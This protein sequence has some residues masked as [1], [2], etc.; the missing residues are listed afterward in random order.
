[1]NFS[2]FEALCTEQQVELHSAIV[3][4]G[5]AKSSGTLFVLE[6]NSVYAA[7]NVAGKLLRKDPDLRLANTTVAI[8]EELAQKPQSFAAGVLSKIIAASIEPVPAPDFDRTFICRNAKSIDSCSNAEGSFSLTFTQ[9]QTPRVALEGYYRPI[10]YQII[11]GQNDQPIAVRKARGELS[12]LTLVDTT[13]NGIPYPAG[14][15]MR[16]NLLDDRYAANPDVYN[17]EIPHYLQQRVGVERVSHAAFIRL[18]AFSEQPS[19]RKQL[20]DLTDLSDHYES[21]KKV[22]RH[23]TIGNLTVLAASALEHTEPL[24]A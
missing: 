5:R 10:G 3:H 21:G 24:A 23:A 11:T 7:L 20:F 4:A 1:M 16:M 2:K 6:P 8:P 19:V 18:S 9:M 12:T 13:I 14:S 15:I 22:L 17:S